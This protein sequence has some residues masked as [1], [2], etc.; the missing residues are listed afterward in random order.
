MLGSDYPYPLGE[1]RIGA[2]VKEAPFLDTS[3]RDDILKNNARNFFGLN[4]N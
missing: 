1:Q 2:L 3:Q 4:Q